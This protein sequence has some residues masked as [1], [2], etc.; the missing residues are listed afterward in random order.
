M[1]TSR[2]TDDGSRPASGAASAALPLYVDLDG[3]LVR[4]DTLH[5]SMLLLIRHSP[6]FVFRMLGWLLG[7]KAYFKR[8]VAE[9]VAPSAQ[10]LPYTEAFLAWLRQERASGRELV[11]A[12]AADRRIAESVA[13]HLGLFTAVL[14]SNQGQAGNLS[15]EGK[16]DA[17]RAHAESMGWPAHAYAG[18]SRDDLP[19]W[20]AAQQAVAVNAPPGVLRRLRQRHP[21]ARVFAPEPVTWRTWL[22]AVRITQWAKNALLFVPLLSAHVWVPEVW[23]QVLLAFVAFGLCA[24]ATYLVNDLLDLPN[25]RQ[26]PHKRHRP[27]AAGRIGMA[28]AVGVMAV[29][30]A[31]ALALAWAVSPAFLGLLLGYTGMTLAYSVY[32]KRVALLD[33]LILSGFYIWRLVAGAVAAGVALSNWLLAISLFLFLGLALVKRCAELEA[34]LLDS[35]SDNARGRGYHQDD[36]P[37]LRAMGVA[38]GFIT[39]TVLALYIGSANGQDLYSSPEWLW[40][41]VPLLLWWTM[42]LWIKIGRRELHGEDPLQFAL[43]DRF[44]WWVLLGLAVLGALASWG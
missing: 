11:L 39:V 29:L 34:V 41:T 20:Q 9:Q 12:T 42:R 14:A 2:P 27:L 21:D 35:E 38:S 26:H 3:T 10:D 8:R 28:S 23:G 5:E 31:L 30:L 33:V 17:I 24:S 4:S 44:S 36:L 22:E 40:G 15:R 32:L 7:G 25:D 43:H 13:A 1:L 19:V 37:G 16:R 6:W 18:N